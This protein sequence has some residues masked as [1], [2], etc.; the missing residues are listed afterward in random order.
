MA[1]HVKLDTWEHLTLQRE[2]LRQRASMRELAWFL[3]AFLHNCLETLH[4]SHHAAVGRGSPATCCK[5]PGRN[6]S[7]TSWLCLVGAHDAMANLWA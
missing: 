6:S 2:R 1:V 7:G 4:T 3:S 5:P